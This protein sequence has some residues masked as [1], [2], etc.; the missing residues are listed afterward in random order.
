[1]ILDKIFVESQLQQQL[2]EKIFQLRR[3]YSEKADAGQ[4]ESKYFHE[5]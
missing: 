2:L 3:Q 4:L 1:M 5:Y